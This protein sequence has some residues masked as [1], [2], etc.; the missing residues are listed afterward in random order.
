MC[1]LWF[2]L[3]VVRVLCVVCCALGGVCVVLFCA[4]FLWFAVC[5]ICGV[6]YDVCAVVCVLCVVV[7]VSCGGLS[8]VR[9]VW[10]A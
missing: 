3:V 1:V 10:C 7:C 9:C 5:D 2:V 8:D 4:E 6:L